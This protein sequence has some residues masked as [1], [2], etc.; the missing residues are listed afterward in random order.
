MTP[1]HIRLHVFRHKEHEFKLTSEYAQDPDERLVNPRRVDDY[2]PEPP[3]TQHPTLYCGTRVWFG[4]H[5][6]Y[7]VRETVADIERLLA[8]SKPKRKAKTS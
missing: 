7:I 5:R 4:S 6:S 3:P 8:S 2:Q 1:K